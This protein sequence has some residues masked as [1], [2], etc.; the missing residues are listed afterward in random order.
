MSDEKVRV[1]VIGVGGMG[2][3]HARHCNNLEEFDLQAVVDINPARAREIG[4]EHEV[5]YFTD[6]R[7]LLEADMVDAVAI[8]TPHYFHPPIAIDCFEAGLHVLSEKP[9]GV[10][11]GWAEKMARAA[12]ESG[13]VFSV[14]FQMR[15]QA[16]VKKARELVESGALGE[17]RRTLL[18]G[19]WYRSQAYYDSGT[20]RATWAGEGGGVLMNQAPHDLD[21]FTMLGGMPTRVQ[22]RCQTLLHDIEVEDQASAM[23]EYENGAIGYLYF[24]TCEKGRRRLEIVGDEAGLRLDPLSFW[25]FKPSVSEYTRTSTEMWGS[26]EIEEVEV[27][28]E[29]C[30]SGHHVVLRN[31]ARAILY[32]EPLIAPGEVG[33]K[34][35]EL[36]NAVTL[37]S[38]KGEA[39]DV[40]IDRQE[41]NELID[42]LRSTSSF[43]E[44]WGDTKSETDPQHL[45]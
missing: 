37:S 12:E 38:H 3:N 35:L 28:L 10:R 36:A 44:D 22:G 6:H 16:N 29:E 1:A 13:K 24:T 25:R 17:I 21:V 33:L 23:L 11:I 31:F 18:I 30:E 43:K 20:W 19:P 2:S 26:P 15:T 40:P 5:R 27:E 7:E 41:F 9:I 32:E 42:Y 39:V 34:S 4:E 45:K 8:A 14:M